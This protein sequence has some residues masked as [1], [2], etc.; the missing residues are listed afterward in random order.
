MPTASAHTA[1]SCANQTH[2]M[3][4]FAID[5]ASWHWSYFKDPESI[6][7]KY[8][9]V[10]YAKK[11]H[12]W[13]LPNYHYR[14]A[15]ACRSPEHPNCSGTLITCTRCVRAMCRRTCCATRAECAPSIATPVSPTRPS[16]TTTGCCTRATLHT[17]NSMS[18]RPWH[19]AAL[20]A[21]HIAGAMRGGTHTVVA[22]VKE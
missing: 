12:P 14:Y 7:V 16:S 19:A 8:Q 22:A 10:A 5:A 18:T 17:V 3:E 4:E 15:M 21:Q 11:G 9:S 20:D 1:S 13:D 2:A 6:A